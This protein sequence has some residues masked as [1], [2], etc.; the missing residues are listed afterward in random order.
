MVLNRKMENTI[1]RS[2]VSD[3]NIVMA[4]AWLSD[5]SAS[6]FRRG[7]MQ[8]PVS[9]DHIRDRCR[10]GACAFNTMRGWLLGEH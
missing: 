4:G 5:A 7:T 6:H 9:S 8:F 10:S 3:R 2:I 1:P